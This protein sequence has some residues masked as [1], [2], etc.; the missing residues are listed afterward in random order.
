[1]ST[2]KERLQNVT[3]ELNIATGTINNLPSLNR[4]YCKC[5]RCN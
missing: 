1:M 5:F 4:S 2:N 3:N